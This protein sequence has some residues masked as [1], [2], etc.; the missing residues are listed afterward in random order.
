M[1]TVKV[2]R[3]MLESRKDK[4]DFPNISP[5]AGMVWFISASRDGVNQTRIIVFKMVYP[6][7]FC[8]LDSINQTAF[9]MRVFISIAIVWHLYFW[10]FVNPMQ[11]IVKMEWYGL[12]LTTELQ[13][14][15]YRRF[16]HYVLI[17]QVLI[18]SK[19]CYQFLL[20]Q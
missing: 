20:L 18:L 9:L 5:P 8:I 13:G 10:Y 15:I 3:V 6:S 12:P 16:V 14:V 17:K 19:Y 11:W 7:I 4:D 2:P 1:F